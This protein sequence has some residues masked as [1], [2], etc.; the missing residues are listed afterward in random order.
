M[1]KNA[2][3]DR[4][5]WERQ[6]GPG[7]DMRWADAAKLRRPGAM[8]AAERQRR[9]RE[10]T[11]EIANMFASAAREIDWERRR[12]CLSS[13]REFIREY[14]MGDGAIFEYEPFAETDAI[15]DVMTAA[16]SA[17]VPYHIR[18]TR[19]GGKTTLMIALAVYMLCRH[20]KKFI[21]LTASKIELATPMVNDIWN[22]FEASDTLAQDFPEYSLPIRALEGNRQR[23]AS[24]KFL[25]KPTLIKKSD[26]VIRFP[27][28]STGCPLLRGSEGG[29]IV[30]ANGFDGKTR[31]L[32]I[33]K[34]R[35]DFILLDDL[36]DDEM[37]KSAEQ[38][39][40]ARQKI[41][42]TYMKLGSSLEK[43][44][45]LMTSTAIE[46]NDL[47]E[48]FARD[49]NF[50]TE[51]F[52]LM[53]Q[54]PN[55]AA[56]ELWRQYKR[57]KDGDIVAKRFGEHNE[58]VFY[59]ANREAMDAGAVPFW[60]ECYD[61]DGTEISAVQH[62]MNLYLEDEESFM[63]EYQMQ[64]KRANLALDL[65]RDVVPTRVLAA[66]GRHVVP[67]G[68]MFVAMATDINHSYAF[69]TV[70]T[71][72]K[73]DRTAHVLAHIISPVSIDAALNDTDFNA[74]L[75][76]ALVAHG[77][78]LHDLGIRVNAWGIDASGRPMTAVCQFAKTAAANADIRIPCCGMMGRAQTKFNPYA[79]N[80]L[81]DSLN[82]TV[83]VG[84]DRERAGIAMGRPYL[85]NRWINWDADRYKE[86][87][88]RALL[89]EPGAPGGCTLYA[90]GNHTDFAIQVT[91][92]RLVGKRPHGDGRDE[93]I[94]E[95]ADP[96]DLLDCLAMDYALAGY[97]GIAGGLSAPVRRLP[98]KRKIVIR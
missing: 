56:M 25:G 26:K 6:V 28:L 57:I 85:G 61:H 23:A 80:R 45:V 98:A 76:A 4:A 58:T 3:I 87:C 84:D 48:T 8:S 92:E 65:P 53:T 27:K 9:H 29:S 39:E 82:S 13:F 74:T 71:A 89:S 2:R 50:K 78:S 93:F 36:Q 52:P 88:Q 24:Q 47:S 19:G 51:T 44:A 33:G 31:G 35:P 62:A 34:L 79:R 72:F 5:F 94:W 54:M 40:K 97:H 66:F 14:L 96:H 12:R 68:Y 32:R 21:V 69:S 22:L 70:I 15:M 55:A 63:S 42:K 91:N 17:A 30:I 38:I 41:Y 75:F 60:R 81:K 95:S 90:D 77:R 43:P 16:S 64:P 10:G 59:A 7:V 37:A 83:L 67:P 18:I 20:D 46:P 1:R 11:G 86:A 73:P 49:P